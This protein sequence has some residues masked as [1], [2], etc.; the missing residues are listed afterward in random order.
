MK[1]YLVPALFVSSVL[2]AFF[3][4]VCSVKKDT[5]SAIAVARLTQQKDSLVSRN[6][7][8]TSEIFVLNIQIG[9]YEYMFDLVEVEDPATYEKFMKSVED[10][11]E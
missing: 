7:D 6:A 3:V 10:K 11:V 8:L 2:T 1:K 9:R 4:G 5:R